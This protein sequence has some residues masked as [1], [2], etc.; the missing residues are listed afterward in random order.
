[1]GATSDAQKERV[2]RYY[3]ETTEKSY[4]AGWSRG[5]LGLHFGL[6]D[7][8]TTS[9]AQSVLQTNAYLADRAG[10][11]RGTRV[12]DA[13]CGVGGSAL[14]LAAERGAVVTGVTLIPEQVEIANR[15]A[16]ER[17]LSGVVDFHCADMAHT[18]L[19][20]RS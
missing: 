18:G 13:G 9:H 7:E 17:G 3:R 10:I 2:L 6:A 12:L 20:P 4:L 1:M 14:W 19:A 16:A 5:S 11:D 15:Y 8:T